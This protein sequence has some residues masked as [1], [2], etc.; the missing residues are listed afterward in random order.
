MAKPKNRRSGLNWRVDHIN[1]Q[2]TKDHYLITA[3]FDRTSG[4]INEVFCSNPM[5]GS[6][7]EAFLTDG[8]ILISLCLQAG[9]DLQYIANTLGDRRLTSDIQGPPTSPFG[10]IV[11]SLLKVEAEIN[12]QQT[13]K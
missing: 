9:V 4:K 2:G 7:I 3:N 13:E 12:Y 5:T 1:S 8:S 6:D 11:R 10:S